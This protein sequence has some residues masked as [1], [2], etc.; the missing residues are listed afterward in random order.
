M[1]RST[2]RTADWQLQASSQLDAPSLVGRLALAAT[3]TKLVSDVTVEHRMVGSDAVLPLR[4]DDR[5]ALIMHWGGKRRFYLFRGDSSLGFFDAQPGDWTLLRPRMAERL[6]ANAP[7]PILVIYLNMASSNDHETPG[8]GLKD[9]SLS[10][11]DSGMRI[12]GG[13]HCAIEAKA[14]TLLRHLHRDDQDHVIDSLHEMINV[15]VKQHGPGVMMGQAANA[16]TEVDLGAT[17]SPGGISA[18]N[19]RGGLAPF[20]LR[21]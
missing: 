14:L 13:H 4:Q 17:V 10:A 11:G 15:L 1:A 9:F 3:D 7:G 16:D 20:N 18:N 2:P 8:A 19:V 12:K 5:H 21:R 6:K